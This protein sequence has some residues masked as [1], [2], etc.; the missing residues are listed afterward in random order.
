MI[1]ARVQVVSEDG[2]FTVAVFGKSLREVEQTA[3]VRYPESAVRIAFPI[4]PE[5]FFAD[6]YLSGVHTNSDT[7]PA[8]LT[9]P[10]RL[11]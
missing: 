8:H 9:N 4:E 3:K 6:G 5:G 2:S 10:M 1:R 11:S 7:R